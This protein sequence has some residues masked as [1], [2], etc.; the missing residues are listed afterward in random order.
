MLPHFCSRL[1]VLNMEQ[2]YFSY[3]TIKQ[4]IRISKTI[5]IQEIT[6]DELA[7]KMAEKFLNKIDVYLKEYAIID[8]RLLR[9]L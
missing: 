9:K 2:L 3:R 1:P 4:A 6:V 7:D 5:H 8:N